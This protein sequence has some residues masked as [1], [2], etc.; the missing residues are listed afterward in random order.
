MDIIGG[1]IRLYALQADV[2]I[3]TINKDGVTFSKR[4]YVERKYHESA[5]IFLTAYDWYVKNAPKITPV[6]EGA[7]FPYWAF[8]DLYSIDTTA[9]GNLLTL[10]VP[11]GEVVLFDMYDWNTI[12]Q[13][14]PLGA[15]QKAI[16]EQLE[17]RGLNENKVM[18]SSFYPELKDEVYKSWQ[19]LFRH[20][21]AL[22]KG[23]EIEGVSLQAGLWRIK[24]E[25]IVSP[26][27]R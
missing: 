8:G 20:H 3:D 1:K 17:S 7:E 11:I 19:A 25:W 27:N 24:R 2:V 6:P 26:Q 13:L 22:I 23:D 4:Q 5:P 12:L 18:L 16:C 15:A 10:D 9:G 14:R 21:D